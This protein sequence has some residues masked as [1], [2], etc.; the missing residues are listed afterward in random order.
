[1]LTYADQVVRAALVERRPHRRQPKA[2]LSTMT[3]GARAKVCRDC[4]GP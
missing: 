2:L 3:A 4:V 1:M